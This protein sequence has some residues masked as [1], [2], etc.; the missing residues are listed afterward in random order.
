MTNH[1]F[2]TLCDSPAS[3]FTGIDLGSSGSDIACIRHSRQF[4]WRTKIFTPSSFSVVDDA[5][6]HTSMTTSS[7][8]LQVTSVDRLS[9]G[10]V[11][12]STK[13]YR[14]LNHTCLLS[15]F[16]DDK[17]IL[18]EEVAGRFTDF[19]G[20]K[21]V[22][23]EAV[24]IFDVSGGGRKIEEITRRPIEGWFHMGTQFVTNLSDSTAVTYCYKSIS[25][26]D[27]RLPSLCI[28]NSH[29]TM[30]LTSNRAVVA[31]CNLFFGAHLSRSH[32]DPRRQFLFFE[33]LQGAGGF[34]PQ[35]SA[36]L[37]GINPLYGRGW[38][39]GKI[40]AWHPAHG[41]LIVVLQSAPHGGE[42]LSRPRSF[43]V[44][45]VNPRTLSHSLLTEFSDRRCGLA[46]SYICGIPVIL[47]ISSDS[48]ISVLK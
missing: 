15:F 23:D 29:P 13:H 28:D 41:N 37:V 16:R 21:A 33:R 24:V 1:R 4:N 20:G 48:Q 46:P 19:K 8:G 35:S 10:P 17:L 38:N 31:G 5:T 39:I 32:D 43:K 18:E 25:L 47:K 9:E 7:E 2:V 14:C 12:C 30:R 11:I 44:F 22:S 40:F 6:A 26:I 42:A 45:S 36:W 27:T 3:A 34:G